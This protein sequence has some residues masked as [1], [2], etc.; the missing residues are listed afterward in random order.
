VI[1]GPGI[2]I[3]GI[4]TACAVVVYGYFIIRFTI[5]WYRL[6]GPEDKQAGNFSTRFTVVVPA[7]N[8][9]DN[10][11]NI[12]TDLASQEIPKEFYEVII[13]D[14]FSSDDT[15]PLVKKFILDHG[16][17][18]FRL[19][20]LGDMPGSI[21]SK[22]EAIRAGIKEAKYD[23]IVT[24]DSDCRAGKGW[25]SG[26]IAYHKKF[27]PAMMMGPVTYEQK[28]GFLAR[29]Q[30]LEFLSLVASGAGAAQMGAAIICNGANL[31]YTK[32]VF[33]EVNGFEGNDLYLS[34]DDVFLMHKVKER[35]G[36]RSVHFIKDPRA[37]VYTMPAASLK[38]LINQ[39]RRWVSKSRGYRDLTTLLVA[40]SVY[41][42]N[43]L[44]LTGLIA[45]IF[46]HALIW[47]ALSGF[48]IKCLVDFPIM[49][50]ITGFVGR[51]KLL[52]EYPAIQVLY[53]PFVVFIG[54]S[55]FFIKGN[56]KGRESMSPH[57]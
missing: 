56:W 14:D 54:I 12:L 16:Q 46:N 32:E 50:G 23:L 31:A 33:D 53:V 51:K 45:G 25:L 17:S 10:I 49:L 3:I 7:R 36:G 38:E 18:N 1:I 41:I 19:I 48:L 8:E 35:F 13:V 2:W 15:A 5:G 40:L 21:G 42:M 55:A 52:W 44:I 39:Q 34:G 22:K 30:E 6:K 47:I 29:F 9:A 24:T 11:L 4:L 37:I 26:I 27:R 28:K 57:P 43:V 20:R